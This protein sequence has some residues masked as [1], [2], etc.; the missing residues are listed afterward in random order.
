LAQA[1]S[2]SQRCLPKRATGEEPT[3]REPTE[4]AVCSE[5][6]AKLEERR[7]AESGTLM[8]NDVSRYVI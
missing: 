3:H 7:I 6:C 2:F 1:L 4:R 5:V 8:R